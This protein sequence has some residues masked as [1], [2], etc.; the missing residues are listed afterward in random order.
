MY[1]GLKLLLAS[2]VVWGT[3]A[4]GVWAQPPPL[5]PPI[6]EGVA[7]QWGPAPGNPHVVYAPNIGGDLFRYGRQH[8]Y[9]YGGRWYRARSLHGPWRAVHRLPRGLLRLHRSAFKS[10]PPW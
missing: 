2:L 8:Y 6:P 3:L 4:G 5:P 1:R 9:Y 7:P 10:A